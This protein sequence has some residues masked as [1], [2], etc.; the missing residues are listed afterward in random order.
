MIDLQNNS[1]TDTFI[2]ANPRK[3]DVS[4]ATESPICRDIA[5]GETVA[6]GCKEIQTEKTKFE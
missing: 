5:I 1:T 4:I 2:P 3:E 6:T